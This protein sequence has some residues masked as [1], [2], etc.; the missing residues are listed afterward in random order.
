MYSEEEIKQLQKW[1]EA[2]N[3]LYEKNTTPL[4]IG[5]ALITVSAIFGVMLVVGL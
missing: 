3:K 4:R 1:N 2:E 5:L